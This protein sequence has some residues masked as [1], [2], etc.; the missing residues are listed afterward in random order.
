MKYPIIRTYVA[1]N[2]HIYS[3]FTGQGDIAKLDIF[4]KILSGNKG[5]CTVGCLVKVFYTFKNNTHRGDGAEKA[6]SSMK[7]LIYMLEFS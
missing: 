2:I 4:I 6:F 5:G 1:T 7:D 3:H